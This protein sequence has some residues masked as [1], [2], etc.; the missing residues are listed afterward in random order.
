MQGHYPPNCY[1]GN[2]WVSLGQPTM[3]RM[4]LWGRQVELA[5]YSFSRRELEGEVATAIYMFFILPTGEFVTSMDA[6][7]RASGDY[8]LRPYGAAQFQVVF[9]AKT[10]EP[11]RRQAVAELLEPLEAVVRT[12]TREG[13]ATEVGAP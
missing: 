13:I 8:R 7:R 12:L 3:E 10:P 11:V 4:T 1:P 2:G 6:V 5:Q 9:D